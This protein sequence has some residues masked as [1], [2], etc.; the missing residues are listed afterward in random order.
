MKL[1]IEKAKKAGRGTSYMSVQA[2]QGM[3]D[4]AQELLNVITAD[5]M[6]PDWAEFSIARASQSLTNVFEYMNHGEGA[7]KQAKV[8]IKQNGTKV[9]L[10]VLQAGQGN[11]MKVKD[12]SDR[13]DDFGDKVDEALGMSGVFLKWEFDNPSSPIFI[14]STRG[15]LAFSVRVQ[16]ELDTQNEMRRRNR[17]PGVD[18]TSVFDPSVLKLLRDAFKAQGIAF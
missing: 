5:T 1:P 10:T 17:L 16:A 8:D 4:H 13:A 3:K 9:R 18:Y 15:G 7:L 6:L 11:F 2:L 12:V 14:E